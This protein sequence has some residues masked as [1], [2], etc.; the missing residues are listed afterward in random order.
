MPDE[1]DKKLL[2]RLKRL[3]G[4]KPKVED[5]DPFTIYVHVVE[6]RDLKPIDSD[7][8][9]DPICT[10]KILN[11]KK[12]TMKQKRTFSPHYDQMLVFDVSLS[13]QQFDS[14]KIKFTIFDTNSSLRNDPLGSYEFDISYI[15]N[16]MDH[17]IWKQWTG[18]FNPKFVSQGI[19]GYIKL[20]ITVLAP[21]DIKK[22][23]DPKEDSDED[24]GGMKVILPP[25]IQYNYKQLV[26]NVLSTRY[27]PDISNRFTPTYSVLI[28]FGDT[29][30][31]SKEVYD[32]G[33]PTQNLND[34]KEQNQENKENEQIDQNPNS[35]VQNQTGHC[36]H[37]IWS[38]LNG[39]F[40]ILVS[41]DTFNILAF[42]GNL[43]ISRKKLASLTYLLTCSHLTNVSIK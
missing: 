3:I 29:R 12:S 36:D 33:E 35:S 40:K 9:P 34:Q 2:S 14:E 24:G 31:R 22:E 8:I 25:F 19:K 37:G 39:P 21:D 30:I 10:V 41:F 38:L 20:S 4:K 23:H 6:C 28:E 16:Q 5:G 42:P 32:E 18:I 15:Y 27:L 11:E 13:P 1:S 26:V 7:D 43:E 17:E